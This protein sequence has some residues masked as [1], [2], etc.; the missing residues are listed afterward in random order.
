[1]NRILKIKKNLLKKDF[2]VPQYAG[3]KY[4]HIF[5][6]DSKTYDWNA[7]ETRIAPIEQVRL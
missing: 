6:G 5:S 3:L 2:F 4:E 7:Y 1:M